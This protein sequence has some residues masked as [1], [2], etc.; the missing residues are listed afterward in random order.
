MVQPLTY[1]ETAFLTLKGDM[2]RKHKPMTV[3]E[4]WISQKTWHLIVR[5]TAIQRAGKSRVTEVR[6]A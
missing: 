4:S 3:R 1:R 6:Q 2:D 5:Q